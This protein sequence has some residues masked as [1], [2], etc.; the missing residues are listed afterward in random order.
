MSKIKPIK[1][2]GILYRSKSWDN[3]NEAVGRAFTWSDY[4]GRFVY[5]QYTEDET[6]VALT[7]PIGDGHVGKPLVADDLEIVAD[8]SDNIVMEM[9]E[10]VVPQPIAGIVYAKWGWEKYSMAFSWSAKQ[11]RFITLKYKEVDGVLLQDDTQKLS[12]TTPETIGCSYI[13]TVPVV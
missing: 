3:F 12:F 8:L 11:S 4:H 1:K 7:M 2:E 13:E 5:V 9:R 10:K 6:G